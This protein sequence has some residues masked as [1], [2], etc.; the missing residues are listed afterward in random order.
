MQVPSTRAHGTT[1]WQ[2][3]A[4]GELAVAGRFAIAVLAFCLWATPAESLE[5]DRDGLFVRV[6]DVGNGHAAAVSMPGGFYMVYDTG[7][8]KRT[9]EG[10]RSIVPEGEDIDLLVVSHTDGDHIGGVDELLEAYRV[11]RIVRPGFPRGTRTWQEA[12]AAIAAEEAAG[13]IVT[14]LAKRHLTPG[15]E[16]QFGSTRVIFVSGFSQPPAS[17]GTQSNSET[18]NAGSIVVRLVFADRSVLFTGDSVGLKLCEENSC[19]APTK[20]FATELFMVKNAPE[21]PI[22]SDVLIAPHH[23]SKYSSSPEFI[24]VVSPKWVV[25]PAG[26]SAFDHPHYETGQRYLAAGVDPTRILRTDRHDDE[27]D[28]EWPCGRIEGNQDR[29][30]DDDVDIAVAPSGSLEVSYRNP[31]PVSL[32]RC[33]AP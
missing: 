9:L 25:I 22:A 15:H 3:L 8:G 28:E 27:G 19:P 14:N 18:K 30:G 2:L 12:D 29:A 24:A 1:L 31:A 10:V 11:R 7:F 6:L 13:A 33:T 21:V 26:R 20:T 32:L 4:H 5:A 17:W 23:G 16:V